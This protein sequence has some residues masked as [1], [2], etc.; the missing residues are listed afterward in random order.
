[1]ASPIS[2]ALASGRRPN[3]TKL[4]LDA[5]PLV[6]EQRNRRLVVVRL[7]AGLRVLDLAHLD[8]RLDPRGA[9]GEEGPRVDA[10][11]VEA[12]PTR[13]RFVPRDADGLA[14]LDVCHGEGSAEAVSVVHAQ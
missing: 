9:P 4:S 14:G 5:C 2:R 3:G 10:I 1:V 6:L 12:T 13:D 8:R 11:E 7:E